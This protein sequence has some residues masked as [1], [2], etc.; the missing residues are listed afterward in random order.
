MILG[1]INKLSKIT[2]DND[3]RESF[4]LKKKKKKKPNASPKQQSKD[5][6]FPSS[7]V[8]KWQPK[9]PPSRSTNLFFFFGCRE[10][11]N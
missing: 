5:S 2:F 8:H 11:T 9:L 4:I 1:K 7:L 6:P 3:F 10:D